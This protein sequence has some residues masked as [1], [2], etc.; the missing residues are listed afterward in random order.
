MAMNDIASVKARLMRGVSKLSES[1]MRLLFFDIYNQLEALNE[2]TNGAPRGGEVSGAKNPK[3]GTGKRGRPR[4]SDE[5]RP[6]AGG[7][8]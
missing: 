6:E 8:A 5:S 7:D 4:K 3:P 1:D 2:A